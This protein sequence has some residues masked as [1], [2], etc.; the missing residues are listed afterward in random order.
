MGALVF[1][2]VK[3]GTIFDVIQSAVRKKFLYELCAPSRDV[4][5]I[6]GN[7]AA[8]QGSF[9]VIGVMWPPMRYS[10]S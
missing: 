3:K 4:L 8:H 10:L 2:L 1:R 7:L 6:V 9:L 5:F